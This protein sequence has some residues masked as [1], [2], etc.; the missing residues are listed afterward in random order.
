MQL[1]RV[2]YTCDFV[3]PRA[4]AS[5]MMSGRRSRGP[6]LVYLSGRCSGYYQPIRLFLPDWVHLVSPAFQTS[7]DEM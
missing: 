4:P 6:L 7:V 5:P 1:V 2:R 3:S